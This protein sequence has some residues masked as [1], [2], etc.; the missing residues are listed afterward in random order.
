VTAAKDALGRAR[1]PPFWHHLASNPTSTI[2]VT[3]A[4]DSVMVGNATFYN[5]QMIELSMLL[6]ILQ[7]Q[8]EEALRGLADD[9]TLAILVDDVDRL[10][11]TSVQ[12][13]LRTLL[14]KIRARHTVT[15]RRPAGGFG[16]R[17]R[18]SADRTITIRLQNMTP[19]EV[20]A[21]IQEQGLLFAEDDA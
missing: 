9:Y 1:N 18:S 16:S 6:S 14:K 11:G 12:E 17:S 19:E 13:W 2:T 7:Q 20:A 8:T 3:Q 4:T 10:D 21:Y 15:A 5:G